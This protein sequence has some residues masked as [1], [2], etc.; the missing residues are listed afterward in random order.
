M[1]AI[2]LFRNVSNIFRCRYLCEFIFYKSLQI[3]RERT[4]FVHVPPVGRPY[5][6]EEVASG[7]VD[8]IKC[9]LRQL[10]NRCVANDVVQQQQQQKS[11]EGM[12][13][14]FSVNENII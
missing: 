12:E 6:A 11:C 5:S 8:I 14:N 13:S 10:E 3:N 7:L 9:A 1:R 2:I 4:I